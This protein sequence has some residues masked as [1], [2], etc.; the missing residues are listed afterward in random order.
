VTLADILTAS[1]AAG[2]DDGIEAL[3]IVV[4]GLPDTDEGR[5]LAG[6]VAPQVMRVAYHRRPGQILDI[7]PCEGEDVL[8]PHWHVT[9]EDRGV[10][11]RVV[12]RIH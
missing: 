10:L 8:P 3:D 11:D 4:V 5:E 1:V 9:V 6:R 12:E 7:R 2:D